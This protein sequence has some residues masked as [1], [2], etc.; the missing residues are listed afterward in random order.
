VAGFELTRNY[1]EAYGLYTCTG[2][3]F[4]HESPRRGF[5]FV[6]RKITSTAARIKLGLEKELRLGNIEAQRDWGFSGEYVKMM[7]IMLQQDEPDDFVIGTGQT[8]TVREF[9]K[10]VFEELELNYEDHLVIDPRFYRPAEVE[11]LV[12]NPT[13]AREKLGWEPKVKF[14]ELALSMV[15]ADYDILMKNK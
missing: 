13:K 14:K 10:I 1:R 15:R 5:E 7:H 9:V 11:I 4:N 3:L 2:M 8:H 6:T 12:A